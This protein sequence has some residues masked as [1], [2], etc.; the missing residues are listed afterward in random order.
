MSDKISLPMEI[1]SRLLRT[2]IVLVLVAMLL[3][4]TSS[5]MDDI[6]V[7][8][9]ILVSLLSVVVVSLFLLVK[10]AVGNGS[11]KN[12]SI[13]APLTS[14]RLI[15]LIV[16]GI[17]LMPVVGGVITLY[18]GDVFAGY[19]GEIA[20]PISRFFNTLGATI[21][22]SGIIFGL[23]LASFSRIIKL[24]TKKELLGK[25]VVALFVTIFVVTGCV[26]I[27]L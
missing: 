24:I 8:F 4:I 19:K 12:K 5:S 11:D 2:T 9:I 18:L 1:N 27:A 20:D 21:F 10:R 17:V 13:R 7:R 25:H 14:K 3:L 15:L 16:G 22:I 6:V 23:T 26:I